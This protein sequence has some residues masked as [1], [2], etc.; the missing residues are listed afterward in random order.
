M[1]HQN[2]FRKDLNLWNRWWHRLLTVFFIGSFVVCI[3]H[4]VLD[5][6]WQRYS[7]TGMLS[8][9]MDNQVRLISTLIRPD[10]KVATN[11][12]G[13][14]AGNYDRNGGWILKQQYYCS[15][16]VASKVDE[17]AETTNV[18][19]YKGNLDLIT[20]DSFKRYLAQNNAICV[21][22]L[23]LNNQW[24]YGDE[25]KALAYGFEADIMAIWQP[26]FIKS[27]SAAFRAVIGVTLGFLV[28]MVIYY[29]IFLY[30]IFGKVKRS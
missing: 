4:V 6:P 14:S 2:F 28:L 10:E 20:L 17:I 7:K 26:S 22:V 18:H 30:I 16:D 21:Q 5:S 23:D 24:K 27:V 12:G 13:L 8:G 19:I 25:Q 15:K 11:E 9:R 3:L 1:R 29:K